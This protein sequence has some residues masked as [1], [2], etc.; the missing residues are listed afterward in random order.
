MSN[1][2]YRMYAR[3]G[4]YG[5][6]TPTHKELYSAM[7]NTSFA[8]WINAETG[9]V[10]MRNQRCVYNKVDVINIKYLKVELDHEREEFVRMFI[11]LEDGLGLLEVVDDPDD[12]VEGNGNTIA[13]AGVICMIV[14][15]LSTHPHLHF[16]S[17]GVGQL[18]NTKDPKSSW[19]LAKTSSEVTEWINASP[20][21][22]TASFLATSK[23]AVVNVIAWNMNQGLPMH[24]KDNEYVKRVAEKSKT[25]RIANQARKNLKEIHPE[26]PDD[27]LTCLLVATVY[28]TAD[29][30]YPDLFFSY[31]T[32]SKYLKMDFSYFRTG[33]YSPNKYILRNL[34]CCQNLDD[35]VCKAIYDAAENIDIDFAKE[36]Q[37]G[38]MS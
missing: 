4:H 12:D 1:Q 2:I 16:W 29:H 23:E 17:N 26:W 21:A 9:H 37:I 3:R 6:R 32:Q 22:G 33:I 10:E 25:H 5:T 34:K 20:T 27:V 35:P 8:T 31:A 24:Y 38:I 28:H 15:A 13:E 30:Y 36:I 11:E 7:I 18:I 19:R 14:G